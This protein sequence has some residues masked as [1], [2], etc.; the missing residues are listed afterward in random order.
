MTN[1][2]IVDDEYYS[3]LSIREKVEKNLDCFDEIYTAY[4]MTD[5]LQLIDEHDIGVMLLDIEMPGGS[6]LDL[7]EAVRGRGLDTVCIFLTAYAR[8]EYANRAMRLSSIDY[9]LKPVKE[10]ELTVALKKGVAE[11][12]TISSRKENTLRASYWESSEIYLIEHFYQQ[13]LQHYLTNDERALRQEL[14]HRNL[15]AE[16]LDENYTLLLVKCE[17][18]ERTLFDGDLFDFTL[19]N[20]LR[21]YFYHEED[22]HVIVRFDEL[23][24]VLLCS[25]K[26]QSQQTIAS[27]SRAALNDFVPHFPNHFSFYTAEK[28]CSFYELPAMYDRIHLIAKKDLNLTNNAIDLSESLGKTSQ[29]DRSFPFEKWS[30][31]LVRRETDAL[32][33]SVAFSVDGMKR[34]TATTK[35]DITSFFYSFLQMLYAA[36]HDNKTAL[37]RFNE[38]ISQMSADEACTS[39]ESLQDWIRMVVPLY[40]MC[41]HSD[42][43]EDKVVQKVRK[44]IHAHLTED[45]TRESLASMVFLNP[46]YLSHRFKKTTGYS[47]TNYIIN[48]RTQEA[49]KMLTN[50]KEMS[51]RDIAIACGFQNLSY[52]AKQFKKETGMTPREFRK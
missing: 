48:A 23:E 51:I 9:L 5:A 49:M 28:A 41:M 18:D 10:E 16:I 27:L 36:M 42:S 17:K 4:N 38:Q 8:F 37:Y 1:L 30:E 50:N 2:L 33:E 21:E 45:L 26:Y 24:F 7:L 34:D 52:F 13:Y 3:L 20:I 15:P 47:L 46:D 44:Y 40:N 19:R 35:E 31:M 25:E 11:W 6:G 14:Q 12:Q 39:I 43:E 22:I 29:K 32:L